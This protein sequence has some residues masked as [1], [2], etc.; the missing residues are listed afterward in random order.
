MLTASKQVSPSSRMCRREDLPRVCGGTQLFRAHVVTMMTR[1]ARRELRMVRPPQMACG[2]ASRIRVPAGRRKRETSRRN[3][4]R[5]SLFPAA[6]TCVTQTKL[7]DPI[8]PAH[9]EA[10]PSPF[11]P[12]A[13]HCRPPSTTTVPLLSRA[14][15]QDSSVLARCSWSIGTDCASSV[16]GVTNLVPSVSST[17]RLRTPRPCGKMLIRCRETAG[18]KYQKVGDER[19]NEE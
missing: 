10:M 2:L 6:L 9:L 8:N 16:W 18:E 7:H 1:V 5:L 14:T 4:Q 12:G 19:W 13:Y 11:V 15:L 3:T 17:S